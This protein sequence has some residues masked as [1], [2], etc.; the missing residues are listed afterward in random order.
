MAGCNDV[1]R[2][3]ILVGIGSFS[4]DSVPVG[5]TMDG[6]EVEKTTDYYDKEV[7]QV[8]DAVDSV[9]TK[10]TMIVRTTLAEA[11]MAH[12]QKVWNE[13]LAVQEAGGIRTMFLG[14]GDVTQEHQIAFTGQGVNGATRTYT[15]F[16]ARFNG[17]SAHSIK[18]DDKVLFP[19]EFRI[20][21]DCT[22]DLGK[23]Y[24]TIVEA[25]IP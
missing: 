18:K 12:L 17:S 22:K 25:I 9:P 23:Q 7:D 6:V 16:R 14:I 20:L 8:L 1:V 15:F 19:V 11:T 10:V 13:K 5:G 21:P 2:G 3:N 4:I 24:G